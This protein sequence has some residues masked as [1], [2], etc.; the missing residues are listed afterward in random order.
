MKACIPGETQEKLTIALIVESPEVNK[1]KKRQKFSSEPSPEQKARVLEEEK[2][3][4][5]LCEKLEGK[6]FQIQVTLDNSGKLATIQFQ[7]PNL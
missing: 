7:E 3:L 2:S 6:I 4:K 1:G 5:A